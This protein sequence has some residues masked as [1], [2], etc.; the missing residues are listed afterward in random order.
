MK[1]TQV[2]CFSTFCVFTL[3][4]VL[5]F[6]EIGFPGVEQTPVK[7]LYSRND[8]RTWQS[9]PVQVLTGEK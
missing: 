9:P 3:L 2:I 7:S 4:V 5:M 8:G 6:L 1:T